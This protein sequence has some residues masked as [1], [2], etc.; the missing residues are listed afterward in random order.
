MRKF[1]IFCICCLTALF[2]ITGTVYAQKGGF[3]G[4]SRIVTA[5]QARTF[6]HRT[7]V[8]LTGNLVLYLGMD[9]YTFRDSSGEITVKIGPREWQGLFVAPSDNIEIS[10][11]LHRD[12]RDSQTVEIHVRNIRKI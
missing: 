12:E 1:L 8:V 7:P 10:G 6:A 4:P 11:E 5:S 3:T 9:R 2:F